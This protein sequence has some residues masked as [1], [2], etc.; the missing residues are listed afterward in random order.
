MFQ[1][2]FA[3]LELKEEDVELDFSEEQQDLVGQDI[4]LPSKKL[5]I[6]VANG[7]GTIPMRRWADHLDFVHNP[8]WRMSE[9][10]S[11]PEEELEL[12]PTAQ[13]EEILVRLM[14]EMGRDQLTQIPD[15]EILP[16]I[17]DIPDGTRNRT[18]TKRKASPGRGHKR[19]LSVRI[20][21]GI[22]LPPARWYRTC[23]LKKDGFGLME[24]LDYVRA[25]P[26]NRMLSGTGEFYGEDIKRLSSYQQP[27]SYHQALGAITFGDF[28][29]YSYHGS[30]MS[31][32]SYQPTRPV[33]PSSPF[34][35]STTG[36]LAAAPTFAVAAAKKQL[37]ESLVLHEQT[38]VTKDDVLLVQGVVGKGVSAPVD[39]ATGGRCRCSC[40]CVAGAA[41]APVLVASAPIFVPGA[42]GVA[43]PSAADIRKAFLEKVHATAAAS[44]AQEGEEEGKGEVA[45]GLLT[46]VSGPFPVNHN[47]PV[48][49]AGSGITGP[50]SAAEF[51]ESVDP[52]FTQNPSSQ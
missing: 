4:L 39:V 42:S 10:E 15:I 27:S 14:E 31:S 6:K 34:F 47:F 51:V 29:N 12:E 25:D 22:A 19:T 20:T 40:S 23:E 2:L 38:V 8:G 11:E 36:S 37:A 48:N 28:D 3:S 44:T 33:T 5:K 41:A 26:L 46:D 45:G 9:G 43:A 24:G 21:I 52:P 30:P 1:G 49:S 13:I 17:S 7:Y 50:A 18:S 32:P 35:L 16:N